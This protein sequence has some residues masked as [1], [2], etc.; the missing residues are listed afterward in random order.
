MHS[1]KDRLWAIPRQC[2][3]PFCGTRFDDTSG[4]HRT[5][6]SLDSRSPWEGSSDP[7]T[8]IPLCLLTIPRE[9]DIRALCRALHVDR[10]YGNQR[11]FR[12]KDM[13]TFGCC[14]MDSCH[15]PCTLPAQMCTEHA[16]QSLQDPDSTACSDAYYAYDSLTETWCWHNRHPS[17][18]GAAAAGATDEDIDLQSPDLTPA[19]LLLRLRTLYRG[20]FIRIFHQYAPQRISELKTFMAAC[21]S[22]RSA[23]QLALEQL[24]QQY[25]VPIDDVPSLLND[26][27]VLQLSLPLNQTDDSIIADHAVAASSTPDPTQLAQRASSPSPL[28]P[29]VRVGSCCCSTTVGRCTSCRNGIAAEHAASLALQQPGRVVQTYEKGGRLHVQDLVREARLDSAPQSSG[30]DSDLS[31]HQ[32][33]PSEAPPIGNES[34]LSPE[35]HATLDAHLDRLRNTL[36]P[37]R[38]PAALSPAPGWS[39]ISHPARLPTSPPTTPPPTAVKRARPTGDTP[40]R[41][42][43]RP[44]VSVKKRGIVLSGDDSDAANGHP[45]HQEIRAVP[46]SQSAMQALSSSDV[47]A[48]ATTS[49]SA[50][51]ILTQLPDLDRQFTPPASDSEMTQDVAQLTAAPAQAATTPP[52]ML[53]STTDAATS[54]GI[55]QCSSLL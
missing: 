11:L 55:P 23:L 21:D 10:W 38:A 13:M 25:Q 20:Y 46:D 47:P 34:T 40:E 17:N 31:K 15:R 39:M 28:A 49:A 45:P 9:A 5:G 36:S 19:D 50:D 54:D 3:C 8:E 42:L 7:N 41:A 2:R 27:E 29:V 12:W 51:S 6:K 30:E 4:R 32:Q 14:S 18:A 26:S 53:T 24:H 33:S 35:E 37:N 22:S 48:Q 1:Y 16:A 43:N 44:G 52:R